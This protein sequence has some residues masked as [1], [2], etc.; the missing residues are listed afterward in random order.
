MYHKLKIPYTKLVP[1]S[2][3]QQLWTFQIHNPHT[4]DRNTQP[5][6]IY[7]KKFII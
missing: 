2:N 1:T 6:A 7:I 4:N 5:T 3:D